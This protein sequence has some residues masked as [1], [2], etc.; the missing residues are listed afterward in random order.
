MILDGELGM[1]L[2]YGR[3]GEGQQADSEYWLGNRSGAFSVSDPP[4]ASS[5]AR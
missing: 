4:L 5:L 2:E 3:A 1:P